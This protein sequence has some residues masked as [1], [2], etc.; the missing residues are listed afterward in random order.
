[1]TNLQAVQQS[2]NILSPGILLRL[3]GLTVLGLAV[4]AYG[5]LEY[6]WL[7]FLLLFF[8]PDLAILVYAV[9]KGWGTAVYNLLHTYTFPIMLLITSILLPWTF[10]IQF[11]IIWFAHIGMDRMFGYGLKYTSE[12][13]DTHLTRL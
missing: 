13:K 3:E 12:F 6:S 11:A 4:F 9:N 7:I 8:W 10:G 1:M 5:R 2:K